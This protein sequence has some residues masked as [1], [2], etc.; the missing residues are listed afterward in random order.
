MG[1]VLKP[2]SALP[3]VVAPMAGGPSTPALV[4]AAGDAGCLGF[5]A[6]GYKT[7]EAVE[8]EI[9]AVRGIT[10]APFGVNLFV[11]SAPIPDAAAVER[12]VRELEP[13]AERYG[14]A[15]GEPRWTDDEWEEKL[16]LVADERPAV[17]SFTF[18]CPEPVLV[19]GL[20]RLGIAVWCTVTDPDEARLGEAAGVDALVAQGGEAGA[21]RGS[22]ED[23]DSEPLGL[24]PLLQLLGA[25]TDLPLVAAGGIVTGA[26]I[27]E[28]LRTGAAAAQLGT[29]F[30]LC[31]EAGT[32]PVHRAALC[33]G[34]TTALTRAFTGRRARG[35]VN[36]F[37]LDH[38]AAPSGY[39][40]LNY[41]TAPLRAAAREAGDPD[42]VNLWAGEA[43]ALAR[44]LPAAE[45]IAALAEELRSASS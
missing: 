30:L 42:G 9:A 32:N 23:D 24:L 16:E 36:R 38:P 28:A 11:P 4:A 20:R 39:P 14:V 22:F 18:G 3:I 34:G 19:E 33:A 44:E 25:V 37:M 35:I 17:V 31:P 10:A 27:A 5:L 29:A 41:A 2:G 8:R 7:A 40:E 21:H 26:G 12:Y 15:V 43:F 45:L 6:A 13:E 1:P